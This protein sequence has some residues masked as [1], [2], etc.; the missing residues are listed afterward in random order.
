[1]KRKDEAAKDF[2]WQ[3]RRNEQNHN[4]DNA[5]GA[6][7]GFLAGVEFAT[8][9]ITVADEEPQEFEK[10]LLSAGSLPDMFVG[11]FNGEDFVNSWTKETVEYF[12]VL[13]WRPIEF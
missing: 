11:Y 4:D 5:T 13:H 9:W 1:M 12:R 7:K 10:V 3:Y 8:K 6:Y 2:A